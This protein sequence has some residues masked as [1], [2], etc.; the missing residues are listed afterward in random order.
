MDEFDSLVQA[1]AQAG[2]LKETITTL[3]KLGDLGD[4]RAL[5][6]LIDM[7]SNTHV[8]ALRNAAAVGLRSLQ[9]NSAVPYLF[10][11]IQSEH[12]AGNR[13]TL[14]YALETLDMRNSLVEIVRWICNDTYEVVAM[15]LR[16]LDAQSNNFGFIDKQNAISVLRDCLSNEDH[17]DWRKEMVSQSIE[18]LS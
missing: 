16:V 2:D 10:A 5:P 17:P 8:D 14:V 18:I 7:L 4:R 13:G 3:H 1:L 9:D 12:T 6:V 15:S 11:Q